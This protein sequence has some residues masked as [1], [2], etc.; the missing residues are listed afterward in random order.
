MFGYI[1]CF[2]PELKMWEYD[3]YK[4]VYCGLCKEMGR[5]YGPFARLTLSYDF[6]FLALLHMAVDE[7]NSKIKFKNQRCPANFFK[8]K[9]CCI[10]NYALEY[11]SDIAML[12]LFYKVKDNI[13]DDNIIKSIPY[14]MI[15]PIAKVAQ[16]KADKKLHYINDIIFNNMKKQSELEANGCDSVDMICE[17]SANSLAKIFENLSCDISQKKVLNRLGFLI[18][19]WV[20]LIDAVDDYFDD[21]K[22]NSYNIFIQK[23]D[24]IIK[25]REDLIEKATPSLNMTLG[26]ISIIYNLLNI[27]KFKSI[28]DNIIFLG[29]PKVQ[30]DILKGYKNNNKTNN[31]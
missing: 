17:P 31:S 8:R 9:S 29:I 18:G 22:N 27:N 19:R 13:N 7:D 24:D 23:Y 14:R 26:E 11:S 1:K 3:L 25:S 20:Y 15:Y 30:E 12:M 4:S 10:D 16:N 6:S 5:L 21:K 28:L 2:K